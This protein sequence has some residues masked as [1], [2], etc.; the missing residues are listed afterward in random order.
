VLSVP[1]ALDIVTQILQGLSALHDAGIVHRDI[2]LENIFL[3]A[4]GHV[5]ILDLGAA[6]RMGE[7]VGERAPSLGT[8]RTMAPEQYDGGIVD[9]RADLY[10]LGIVLYELLAGRGPFDDVSGLEAL[11]FAHCHRPAPA[12]SQFAPQIIASEID[13][14]VLRALAKSPEDR[15]VSADAM[16]VEI[17]ALRA[18]AM[19]VTR[20]V[21]ETSVR[22]SH[23]ASVTV[24]SPWATGESWITFRMAQLLKP[25]L[26]PVRLLSIA[27]LA[28]VIASMAF[29]IAAGQR[30]PRLGAAS[31]LPG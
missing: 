18:A 29:G 3:C 4:D 25:L 31:C 28:L 24:P 14:F 7:D 27:I 23:P 10:A 1:T 13:A 26:S 17:A 16:A 5:E 6:E 11:R 21:L 12:P 30:L 15:F 9:G 8:P 22:Q 19:P 20:S 2:K